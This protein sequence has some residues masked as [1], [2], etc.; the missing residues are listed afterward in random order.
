MPYSYKIVTEKSSK[1]FIVQKNKNPEYQTGKKIKFRGHISK[2]YNF[3]NFSLKCEECHF[4]PNNANM[5][6][7]RKTLCGQQ[8]IKGKNQHRT[9]LETDRS[10]NNKFIFVSILFVFTLRICQLSGFCCFTSVFLI[11]KLKAV[12]PLSLILPTS[13]N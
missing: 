2:F 13:I 6:V 9:S 7:V 12:A 1:S 10:S 5:A 3:Y 8:I 4:F 11:D